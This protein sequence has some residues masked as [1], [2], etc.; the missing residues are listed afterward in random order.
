MTSVNRN[1]EKC[2]CAGGNRVTEGTD[3]L[4]ERHFS[5]A[6]YNDAPEDHGNDGRDR[7]GVACWLRCS[8][9]WRTGHAGP[10]NW[11]KGVGDATQATGPS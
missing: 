6:D 3:P 4:M 5:G 7:S 2:L 1:A 11:P 9:T 10:C 8:L